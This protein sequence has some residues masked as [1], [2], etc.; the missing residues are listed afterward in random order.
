M[1]FKKF[2]AVATVVAATCA[3]FAVCA[4]EVHTLAAHF[5][6]AFKVR[7]TA[8][9]DAEMTMPNQTGGVDKTGTHTTMAWTTDTKK[10][11][12]GYHA[13]VAI[14][15]MTMEQ[16]P[17]PPP[18]AAPASGATG[19]TPPM[20]PA[21]MAQKITALLKLI[22]NAEVSYDSQMRPLRVDNLDTLKANVKSMIMMGTSAQDAQKV[23]SIFDL[24]TTDITPEAAASLLKQGTQSR[25]PYGKPLALH[26]TV[27][28]DPVT[29]EIYGAKLSM[30]GTATLD[31]WEEGKAAHLTVV[32]QPAEADVR[33]FATTLV[34]TMF[35]K[36]LV[37]VGKG[38]KP[39]EM[40]Q[41]KTMIG[42]VIN[43]S[44][45][46]LVSTCKVDVDLTNTALT[47]S[48][49]KSN[50]LIKIDSSKVLT[51]EQLKANPQAAAGFKVYTIAQTSHSV[52][53][54]VLVAN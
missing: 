3:P 2:V 29:S 20:D 9:N 52:S 6:D 16:V 50:V 8:T 11:A 4:Q 49:C 54:S 36:I 45:I 25:L 23:T 17:P 28:L 14:E 46:Q 22:G 30:G 32:V 51:E 24:F 26:Q 19:A 47:H 48:D 41:V 31:S 33:S 5:P 15:T 43:G 37:A 53:D 42:R 35:D 13:V 12:T 38:P 27:A 44:S 39:E 1:Y 34:N 7:S 18:P 21:E 40:T 10:T